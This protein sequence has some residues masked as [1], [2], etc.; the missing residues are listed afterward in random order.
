[1]TGRAA[2]NP[3]RNIPLLIAI[4][5]SV[6]ISAQSQTTPRLPAY[7]IST[8]KLNNSGEHSGKF[9]YSP[10]GLIVENLSL[11]TLIEQAYEVEKEQVIGAPDWAKSERY[12]IE[13]K[14]DPS[15]TEALR[16]L[17]PAQRN[18]MMKPLLEDRFQLKTHFETRDLPVYVLAISK[19]GSKL[20]KTPAP[21]TGEEKHNFNMGRDT[22]TAEG[23]SVDQ[24]A[25]L[26]STALGRPVANKT[27]LAGNYD[28]NMKWEVE[29]IVSGPS[30]SP[31][32]SIFTAIQQQLGLKLNPGKAPI[33]VLVID[34]IERPSEN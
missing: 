16:S 27:A 24:L 20:K 13:A 32:P 8:V 10:A 7:E 33:Q 5:L 22:L 12:D 14:V 18:R 9:S 34:H 3:S 19:T 26:L 23:I 28:I 25:H 2:R 1:M 30:A 11:Q 15:E 31:G 29:D 17:T 6:G 4:S 21:G